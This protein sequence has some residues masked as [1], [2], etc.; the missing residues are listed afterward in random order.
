MYP[1]YLYY[2]SGVHS[3]GNTIVTYVE[4]IIVEDM[5]RMPKSYARV[6]TMGSIEPV[7]VIR[8]T[9]PTLILLGIPVVVAQQQCFVVRSP[10]DIPAHCDEVASTFY[11]D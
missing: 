8:Y 7:V 5:N 1:Q 10:E 6:S 11:V 9:E 4:I 3:T 2:Q